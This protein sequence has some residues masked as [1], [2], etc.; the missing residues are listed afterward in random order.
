MTTG[1]IIVAEVNGQQAGST[2]TGGSVKISAS[3][4]SE[5]PLANIE[6]VSNG[7]VVATLTPQN[8]PTPEGARQSEVTAEIPVATSGWVCLRCTED[9]PDRRLRFAHTAPWWLDVPGKPLRPTQQEKDYLIAR[10]KAEITRSTG[11]VPASALAEYAAAL[12]HFETMPTE[13]RQKD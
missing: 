8:K 3:I 12:E 4:L 1:P 9:R 10:V 7:K 11:I 6:V 5:H 2:L 13:E